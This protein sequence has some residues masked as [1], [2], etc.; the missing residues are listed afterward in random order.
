MLFKANVNLVKLNHFI[1]LFVVGIYGYPSFSFEYN[2]FI[3]FT[4]RCLSLI[5]YGMVFIFFVYSNKPLKNNNNSKNILNFKFGL[6]DLVKLIAIFLCL[7]IYFRRELSSSITGDENYLY[8]ASIEYSHYILEKIE[9][10]FSLDNNIPARYLIGLI[11]LLIILLVVVIYIASEKLI[12]KNK[13]ITY[14]FIIICLQFMHTIIFG[15]SFSYPYLEALPYFFL[16]PI[17][18]FLNLNPKIIAFFMFSCF[19]FYLYKLLLRQIKGVTVV[20]LV[21]AIFTIN[22]MWDISLTINHSI[23][24]VYIVSILLI[25]LLL[26]KKISTYEY[27]IAITLSTFRPTVF[28][29]IIAIYFIENR[30]KIRIQNLVLNFVKY[31]DILSAVMLIQIPLFFGRFL[32]NLYAIRDVNNRNSLNLSSSVH[33]FTFNIINTDNVYLFLIFIFIILVCFKRQN[34]EF[35]LIF[36]LTLLIFFLTAPSKNLE[37]PIYKVE[38]LSPFLIASIIFFSSVEIRFI[39]SKVRHLMTILFLSSIIA[40][41]YSESQKQLLPNVSWGQNYQL[42]NSTPPSKYFTFAKVNYSKILLG[43]NSKF[44]N[45]KFLDTTYDGAFLLSSNITTKNFV[46]ISKSLT[47]NLEKIQV[48]SDLNCLIVGNFPLNKFV[49][50]NSNLKRPFK[51]SES[52]RNKDLNTEVTVFRR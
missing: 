26:N 29:L 13:M 51:L 38:I 34:L 32:D 6:S 17:T 9:D 15:G 52:F 7:L 39:R 46:L 36:I 8:G 19:I 49:E 12:I 4:F 23:Y 43:I 30:S 33:Q 3:G 35:L 10:N 28:M 48:E 37:V 5:I 44:Q 42:A 50:L 27:L 41:N 25:K 47:T 20:L 1:V 14:G 24:F 40:F 2:S 21:T 45:C 16:S 22:M 18:L 11:Q 31:K